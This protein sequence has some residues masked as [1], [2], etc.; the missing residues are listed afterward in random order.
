MPFV[1]RLNSGESSYG[2][3]HSPIWLNSYLLTP[4]E[5]TNLI[6][7]NYMR[8]PNQGRGSPTQAHVPG[9]L[10]FG[11]S[12]S[13]VE[14]SAFGNN[15]ICPY[16]E[17][18]SNHSRMTRSKLRNSIAKEAARILLRSGETSYISARKKATRWL[19]KKKVTPQDIPGKAEIHSQ[20][21]L[22]SGLFSEEYRQATLYAMRTTAVELMEALEKFKPLLVGPVAN[23]PV[24]EG[25]EIRLTVQA[26]NAELVMESLK[27]FAV[28]CELDENSAIQFHN[29]FPCVIEIVSG[30]DEISET[31]N[32][33]DLLGFKAL[34]VGP[35][36][37]LKPLVDEVFAHDRRDTYRY[38]EL[39]LS[40][41]NGVALDPELHPEGD[42]LYHS[43]QVFELGK[44]QL[45]YDEE[46]L[47][48]CLLHEVGR[49]IDRHHA[50]LATLSALGDMISER[51]HWLI[52]HLPDAVNYLSTGKISKGIRRHEQFDELMLFTECDLDGTVRGFPVS[53][54]DE[55]ISYLE[56]IENEWD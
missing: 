12:F 9:F 47:Q 46:F 19:S 4:K 29:R 6:E 5:P 52:E 34:L 26:E 42:A 14:A 38:L 35:N 50:T 1:Q 27:R 54:L 31:E 37:D 51:T 48:A 36:D 13:L 41:L 43:L 2:N 22:Q 30:D 32:G 45:P 33:I 39:L 15:R 16:L 56:E 44:Q 53:E 17:D 18:F 55:A 8:Y 3:R 10:C 20:M 21:C 11:E 23:P 24:E 28:C 49:A 25:V 7:Q 40:R